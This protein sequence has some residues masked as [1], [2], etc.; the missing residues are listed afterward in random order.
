MDSPGHSAQYCTY[1]VMDEKT[2]AIVALE[3]VDKR[4]T[5]RKS[6]IMEKK[7][8]EKAMD[9]LLEADVPVKE[10]CTDAHPQIGALMSKCS[11]TVECEP[12]Y[13]GHFL[14]W[15]NTDFYWLSHFIEYLKLEEFN[16]SI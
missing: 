8:F 1:T 14:I 9:S 3:V 6:A 10:V 11:E 2:R 7:G 12:N 5:E 15:C 16:L 13:P 4:E